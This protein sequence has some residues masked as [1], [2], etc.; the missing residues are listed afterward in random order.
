MTN[1]ELI[2]K[3]SMLDPNAEVVVRND[4]DHDSWYAFPI[5]SV[6]TEANIKTKKVDFSKDKNL[7]NNCRLKV[8]EEGIVLVYDDKSGV[9]EDN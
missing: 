2:M 5:T 9:W 7:Q 3:L 1:A 6:F 8:I 4:K